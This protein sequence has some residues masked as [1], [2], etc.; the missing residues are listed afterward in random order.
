MVAGVIGMAVALGIFL[1][2]LFLAKPKPNPAIADPLK[3][4]LIS[5]GFTF[6]ETTDPLL[7]EINATLR[8]TAYAGTLEQ[9]YRRSIDDLVVCWVSDS[10]NN[11]LVSMIAQPFPS[12]P[13]ILLYL[14]AAKGMIGSIVRKMFD[15]ALSP[16]HFVRVEPEVLGTSSTRFELYSPPRVAPPSFEAKF[17]NMLRH[18]GNLIL[19]SSGQRLLI[20]RLSLSPQEP[21]EEEIRQLVRLTMMLQNAL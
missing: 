7:P 2:V 4:V 8:A 10:D 3:A 1:L 9:A 6:M 19:R 14:P 18:C 11:H 12:E 5:L 13:W 17:V 16:S 21:W 20:E 15:V